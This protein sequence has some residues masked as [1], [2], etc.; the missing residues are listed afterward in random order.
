MADLSIEKLKSLFRQNLKVQREKVTPELA[1]EASESLWAQLQEQDFFKK[2]RRIGAFYSI[3]TEINMMP[4]L[5]GIL[6]S[7]KELY[8][9]RIDHDHALL[10]FHPA[11]DLSQ[12]QPG[13]FNT[14]EPKATTAIAPGKLDLILV[15]GLAFDNRGHRLGY[16]Q[17]HYDRFLKVI[18]KDCYVLGVAYSFQII[19]KTPNAEHDIPVNAVLT[20]KFILLC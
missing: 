9:P 12:L 1:Q 14:M 13:P 11:P 18:S 17:G 3:T 19:D 15:P 7:G 2:A 6:A 10:Q 8:L 20:D 4:L 5:S 16:G